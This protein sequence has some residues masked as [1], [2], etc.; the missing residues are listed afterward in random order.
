MLFDFWKEVTGRKVGFYDFRK[1]IYEV[2]KIVCSTVVLSIF[3]KNLMAVKKVFMVVLKTMQE[4]FFVV[5]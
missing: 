3:E 1:D 4:N 5:L 2:E